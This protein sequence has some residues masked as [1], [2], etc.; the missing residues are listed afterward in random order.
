MAMHQLND[1]VHPIMYLKGISA[2]T[3]KTSQRNGRIRRIPGSK[4]KF[5][6]RIIPAWSIAL[7]LL[8]KALCADAFLPAHTIARSKECFQIPPPPSLF[9][10]PSPINTKTVSRGFRLW[11]RESTTTHVVSQNLFFP[12]PRLNGQYVN[13]SSLPTAA[14]QHDGLVLSEVDVLYE[15]STELVYD[16]V[17]DRYR[18]AT[19]ADYGAERTMGS[20]GTPRHGLGKMI[21][22]IIGPRLSV[23]FLPAGVTPNYYRFMRWRVLQRFVNANL[24]VFGTQSLLMGLGIKS[25]SSQLGALSAA[26]KWVLKDALGKI[27]RMTW[28]SR[29]GRR[30]DSDAKRWRFRS[31]FVFALGNFLEITTY[32]IPS[33][34]LVWATLAN[35][36]KQ[37][38]MLTSSS[39]RTAI[40]N[41]FRDGS[42]ENIGDIT[43]KG[44][45]Q[46]AVVDLLGIASGVSLSRLVGTSVR[47]ILMVY[48]MLQGLEIVCMYRQLRTVVYRVLN[49]E[50]LSEV[51]DEFLDT[52]TALSKTQQ[53]V[54]NGPISTTTS[55]GETTTTGTHIPTMLSSPVG[56]AL[57]TAI[58]NPQEMARTERIFLPP[59]HLSRRGTAFGSLGRTKMSPQELERLLSIFAKERFLLIVGQNIK[60]GALG[61]AR[62][63]RLPK[64]EVLQENCHIVLHKDATN[65]DIAKSSMALLLLRRKLVA[66][67]A[68]LDPWTVRSSDCFHM[69]EESLKETEDLY[70]LFRK[71]LSKQGWES[72]ARFMFGRVHMRADWPLLRQNSKAS[73]TPSPQPS[74]PN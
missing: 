73:P 63:K 49:F 19:T 70:S 37:V 12:L 50:R 39:T 31:A 10:I 8:T 53:L 9:R 54:S 48:V 57:I 16:P 6:D 33:M 26:L 59:R 71:Q 40:Y 11:R 36:C 41:S 45:A 1:D 74:I 51:I 18:K 38:S 32:M 13:A 3:R 67:S 42:R 65:A 15:R 60:K 29:M 7:Y 64:S 23:A 35:C 44:E 5:E 52:T 28:A 17:E 68:D 21:W 72:P 4:P 43:A 27:V 56:P 47:S 46:I 24:H 22:Q 61:R 62:Q 25:S 34:F 14:T 2:T 30:F 66:A 20:S 69:L 58:K 55:N